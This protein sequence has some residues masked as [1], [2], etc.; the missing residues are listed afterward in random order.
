MTGAGVKKGSLTVVGLGIGMPGQITLESI[1]VM[2]AADQLF[3]LA[4]GLLA[5]LCVRDINPRAE[6]LERFY[7]PGE[8]RA[9]IYEQIAEA[10][11]AAVTAGKHVCAAFYGHPGVLVQA[12][13]LAIRRVRR[14]G[15]RATMLPGVSAEACLFADLGVN[16][17]DRGL[18]SYEAT[19]FLLSRRRIDPT[20]PLLLWQVEVLGES[21]TAHRA[22]PRARLEVLQKRLA[23]HYPASHR[24]VEYRAGTFPGDPPYVSRFALE[25]LSSRQF[26]LP[27]ILFVP[28]MP[29]RRVDPAVASWLRGTP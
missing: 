4:P 17:G 20:V 12:S 10:L 8:S 22:T 15:Y 28:P 5:G 7:V 18:Q 9:R 6:S 1:E 11:V 3:F 27:G 26:S 2:R 19:D 23:R 21:G 25:R 29:Q 16:P 24:L 14:A 13:H